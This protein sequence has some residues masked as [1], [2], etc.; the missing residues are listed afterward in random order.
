[1]KI[2]FLR[3]GESMDDIYEEFGGWGERELSPQGVKTALELT[4]DI[5]GLQK[6]HGNFK[7][8]YT[9]P[10]TRCY[11]TAE[12]IE[13]ELEIPSKLLPYLKERNT[14]GLLSGVKKKIVKKEYPE[15]YDLYEKQKYIPGAERYKDFAERIKIL[16]HHLQ[17]NTHENIVCV[18][19]GHLITVI[20]EEILGLIKN[21]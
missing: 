14:Y 15:L 7:V 12:I 17:D 1:M 13:S 4:K 10:L 5:K 8:I 21:S 6:Q 16:M 2:L 18:T 19:H 9:S 20:L 11:Q 3:H